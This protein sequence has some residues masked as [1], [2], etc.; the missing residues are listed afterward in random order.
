MTT[1]STSAYTCALGSLRTAA[2]LA[3]IFTALRSL[4][5]PVFLCRL[6]FE[7]IYNLYSFIVATF[8][9]S[10]ERVCECVNMYEIANGKSI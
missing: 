6:S 7:I 3:A 5:V 2:L 1:R 9:I 10:S 4:S 8:G